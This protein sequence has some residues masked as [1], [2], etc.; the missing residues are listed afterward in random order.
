[1]LNREKVFA[2]AA[3]VLSVAAIVWCLAGWSRPERWGEPI[4]TKITPRLPVTA[5]A[6]FR[7]SPERVDQPKMESFFWVVADDETKP[8]KA[9]KVVKWDWPPLPPEQSGSRPPVALA[10]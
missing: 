3:V 1:M 10:P 7:P 5:A 8:V 9:P 2:L 4:S 6:F